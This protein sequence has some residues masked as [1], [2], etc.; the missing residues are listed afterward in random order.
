MDLINLNEE[1]W[2][3]INANDKKENI[4]EKIKEI[5]HNNEKIDTTL[6]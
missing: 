1:N 5:F 6:I 3:T 2:Y 4:H